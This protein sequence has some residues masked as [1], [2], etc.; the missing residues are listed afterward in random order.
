MAVCAGACDNEDHVMDT[1]AS[2]NQD[3]FLV[4]NGEVIDNDGDMI[5]PAMTR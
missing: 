5:V 3:N 1:V 2:A 4:A